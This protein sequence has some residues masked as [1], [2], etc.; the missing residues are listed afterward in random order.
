MGGPRDH[1][2]YEV[3]QRQILYGITY[4]QNLNMMQMNLH[5]KQ[6]QTHRHVK[7]FMVSKGEKEGR[8]DN[9]LIYRIN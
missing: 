1:H 4:R 2:T 6:K 9:I 7:K 5:T 8:R 3:R